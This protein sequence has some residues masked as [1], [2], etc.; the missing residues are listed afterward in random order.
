MSLADR[1]PSAATPKDKTL[2]GGIHGYHVALFTAWVLIAGYFLYRGWSYYRLPLQARPFAEGYATFKPG[3]AIGLNLGILGTLMMAV[4]VLT[5]VVRKRVRRFS[6]WGKLR[7]WLSFHIFLCTLGPFLVLLHTSFKVNG[8]VAISFLSMV[9][10]VISGLTGRFLYARVPKTIN[11][12]VRTLKA[13]REERET[14]LE[15]VAGEIGLPEAHLE[16]LFP[17]LVRTEVTGFGHAFRVAVQYGLDKRKRKQWIVQQAEALGI[18]PV[19]HKTFTRLVR[20]EIRLER[21][22]ALLTPFQKLFSYWHAV[23]IPLTIVM[24]VVVLLHIGVAI[25]FGYVIEF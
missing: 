9:V 10:V 5:Y 21:H 24:G 1:I 7:N 3:G 15:A 11:G 17:P 6:R 18:A 23:H 22:I 12:Q 14:L 19:H 20:D 4:G 13:L 16:T 25:A 8:L 2:L